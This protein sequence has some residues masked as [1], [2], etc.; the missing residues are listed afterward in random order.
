MAIKNRTHGV[1]KIYDDTA[2][3]PLEVTASPGEGNFQISGIQE[4]GWQTEQIFDRGVPYE[5]VRTQHAEVS[6]SITVMHDGDLTDASTMRILDLVTGTGAAASATTFDSGGIVL[7]HK[8]ELTVTRSGV[9]DT[10]DIED[11]RITAD[12]AEGESSNTITING[13]GYGVVNRTTA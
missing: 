12:Y 8:V 13:T 7:T 5:R 10:I 6:F 2:T 4:G 9:T 11:C 1:V 3:T